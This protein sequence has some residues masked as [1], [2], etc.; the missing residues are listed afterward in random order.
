MSLN[1][2]GILFKHV[3]EQVYRFILLITQKEV[4][5]R[6]IVTGQS[7]SLILL[8]LLRTSAAHI[9][10][11]GCGDRQ[12][13]KQQLQHI[14]LFLCDWHTRIH[15]NVGCRCNLIFKT[16]NFAFSARKRNTNFKPEETTN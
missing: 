7:V 6:N 2:S 13:Q 12:K 10:A 8:C 11:I 14:R 1:G 5:P 9:P 16:F 3:E 4:Y 15:W